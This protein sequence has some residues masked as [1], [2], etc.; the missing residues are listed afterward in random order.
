MT[1]EGYSFGG[2]FRNPNLTA[3]WSFASSTATSNLTL[4]AKWVPSQ[5]KVSFVPNGGEPDPD[6]Q[7]VV[8]GAKAASPLPMTKAGQGFAGWFTDDVTFTQ[9]RTA[10]WDFASDT[11]TKDIKLYAKWVTTRYKVSFEPNGGSPQPSAQQVAHNSTLQRP[12]SM[13]KLGHQFGGWYDNANF[14]GEA[15]NFTSSKVDKDL[16]VLYAKW[17]PDQY[18]VTFIANDGLPVPQDQRVLYESKVTRPAPMTRQGHSFGGWYQSANFTGASWDFTNDTVIGNTT[19]YAK[20]EKNYL[21]VIFNP[22]LGIPAPKIQP[23]L[24]DA[25]VIPPAPMQRPEHAFGGWYIDPNFIG[26]PWNFAVDRVSSDMNLYAKWEK[27]PTI[28]TVVFNANGG[29]PAP[30][31][32]PVT[33]GTRVSE[34]ASMTKPNSGFG[35]WFVGNETSSDW[36]EPWIFSLPMNTDPNFSGRNIYGGKIYLYARWTEDRYLVR[37][38]ANGGFPMPENQYVSPGAKAKEPLAMNRPGYGFDGWYEDP[39]L[40]KKW[41]FANNPVNKDDLRLY[42]KWVRDEVPPI[43]VIQQI[44]I[45]GVYYIHFAGDSS[46]FNGAHGPGGSTDLTAAQIASNN[47]NMASVRSTFSGNP[48]LIIQLSG[49]ANPVTGTPGEAEELRVIS[50]QRAQEIYNLLSK[51]PNPIP[52]ASMINIGFSDVLYGDPGSGIS[53]NRIVEIIIVEI[54]TK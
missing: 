51:P 44:R 31:S 19:L 28:I 3:R 34:P 38:E 33:D 25:L 10:G 53:L 30:A 42:A 23:V 40:I 20:W 29:E 8:Y 1:R 16:M 4:Y 43:E 26:Y 52:P 22:N 37:F 21:V 14:S 2:W 15:W 32:Q 17:E 48:S 5:H 18:T 27:S 45:I 36:K 49:H 9:P 12:A 35:G 47:S 24:Y 13:T 7:F 6:D 11:V 39:L 41:D 46:T 54:L 50:E